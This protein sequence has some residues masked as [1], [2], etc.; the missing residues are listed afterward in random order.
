M[1]K[2]FAWRPHLDRDPLFN[3]FIPS[4]RTPLTGK[5]EISEAYGD[6]TVNDEA[7]PSSDA[8]AISGSEKSEESPPEADE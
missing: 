8:T 2:H 4:E 3:P 6:D 5:V 7:A 1:K